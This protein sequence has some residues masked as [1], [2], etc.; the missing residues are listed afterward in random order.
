MGRTLTQ[1]VCDRVE[2]ELEERRDNICYNFLNGLMEEGKI[3]Y[4][5]AIEYFNPGADELDSFL[6]DLISRIVNRNTLGNTTEDWELAIWYAIDKQKVREK[7]KECAN[8]L[9]ESIDPSWMLIN[10]R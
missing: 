5:E 7:F 9:S 10:Q 4:N 2:E 8:E 3:L 6:D 1:M